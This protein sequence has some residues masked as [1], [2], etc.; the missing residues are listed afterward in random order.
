MK[1][2]AAQDLEDMLQYSLPTFDGLLGTSD[3]DIIQDLLFELATWHA[4]AKLRIHTETTLQLFES[5]IKAL[6]AIVQHFMCTTCENYDTEELPRETAAWSHH[7]TK[8]QSSGKGKG[9]EKAG[10]NLESVTSAQKKTLNIKTYKFYVLGDYP[11][12]IRHFGPTDN[13]TTQT[14]EL[15]HRRVK[16]FYA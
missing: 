8:K 10:D 9:K 4:F 11:A 5:S 16:Q 12:A 15:E 14:G 2:L 6:G 1:K 13:F 3:D 7:K